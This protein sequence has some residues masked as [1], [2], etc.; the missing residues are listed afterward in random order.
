VRLGAVPPLAVDSDSDGDGAPD[1]LEV[2]VAAHPLN[3]D[4][5]VANGSTTGFDDNDSTG[6]EGDGI[7]DALERILIFLGCG[8]P[9]LTFG[10]T[11]LDGI[12]DYFEA[13]RGTNPVDGDS[14]LVGGGADSN[15]GTGPAGDGLSDGLEAF[16][17][18]SGA[19]G[20]ITLTTDT[21]LDGVPDYFE[22]FKG[23]NPFDDQSFILPGV[24]PEAQGVTIAG[25]NFVGR[26]LIGSYRYVDADADPEGATTLRWLREG[27]EIPGETGFTHV[28]T[29]EDTGKNLTFEVVPM[30][31]FAFP[32]ET[33]TGEAFTFTRLVPVPSFPHGEGGPGGVDV[34]LL[35]VWLR[36]DTGVTTEDDGSGGLQVTT[37]KDRRADGPIADLASGTPPKLV[38][39]VGPHQLKAI[40]FDGTGAL[41]IPRTIGYHLS[42]QASFVSTDMDGSATSAD[43][44]SA[45]AILCTGVCGKDFFLGMNHGLGHFVFKDTQG[46]LQQSS[47]TTVADGSPHML[48]V[49]RTNGDRNRL[50]V[51]GNREVNTSN[52]RSSTLD[53][54]PDMLIGTTDNTSVYWN[55]DLFEVITR[56]GVWNTVERI[57]I[58]HYVAGR[59]GTS[60][61]DPEEMRYG[62]FATHYGDIAGIGKLGTNGVSSAE[63]TG[64]VKFSDPS[65]LS[66]ED[67]LI[68]GTD[69]PD[70]FTFSNNV[71]PPFSNRL[72]RT[73]AY[74]ITDG[75]TGGGV[76]K[77]NVSFLI[78]GLPITAD[79]THFALLLDSDT[80][81]SDA[82]FHIVG[83]TLSS[84]PA[85]ISFTDVLLPA[86]SGYFTLACQ[87]F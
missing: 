73:W 36:A 34:A 19:T 72:K 42:L 65:S 52:N 56:E 85:R 62:F 2:E 54:S 43:W 71:T 55:G 24:K 49:T 76:G 82:S 14:P 30:S 48:Q 4:I 11:D 68:W 41:K 70:D 3:D 1:Y 13:L 64:M 60:L 80:D 31:L 7:S 67:F 46:T 87:P 86:A 63:G 18:A 21:D 9:V 38:E 26:T 83:A 45:P 8:S 17:L 32:P 10:D 39:G 44:P 25:T 15:D 81:F 66:D 28:I 5:P 50:Y 37:W 6:P 33:A 69:L 57:L 78:E 59:I 53:C 20:P 12:P 40:R 47:T 84:D 79:V 75:P 35:A 77:V 27:V 51:D 16:L 74:T 61:L 23:S 58:D 22:V 29:E